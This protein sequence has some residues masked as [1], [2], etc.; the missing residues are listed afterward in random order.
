MLSYIVAVLFVKVDRL[1][2]FG[3]NAGVFTAD[4]LTRLRRKST[5]VT[6]NINNDCS[7]QVYQ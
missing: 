4:T 2:R 3:D 6:Y 5:G 7:V 1:I